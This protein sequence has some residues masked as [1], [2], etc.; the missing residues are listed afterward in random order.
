MSSRSEGNEIEMTRLHSRSLTSAVPS[1]SISITSTQTTWLGQSGLHAP[2]TQ[3][4]AVTNTGRW[5][6]GLYLLDHFNFLNIYHNSLS[7]TFTLSNR[8]RRNYS[9]FMRVSTHR[10][11]AMIFRVKDLQVSATFIASRRAR[12]LNSAHSTHKTDQRERPYL[13]ANSEIPAK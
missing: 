11:Q 6:R 4:N 2:R 1:I 10:I 7:I 5:T 8:P 12:I 13:A 3:G 9:Q